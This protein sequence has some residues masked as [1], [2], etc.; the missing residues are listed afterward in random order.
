MRLLIP[1]TAKG[2]ETLLVPAIKLFIGLQTRKTVAAS[3]EGITLLGG[4]KGHVQNWVYPNW[5]E[6]WTWWCQNDAGL[7]GSE[8]TPKG[9]IA[10]QLIDIL[11]GLDGVKWIRNIKILDKLDEL[12]HGQREFSETDSVEV[13]NNR[14]KRLAYSKTATRNEWIKALLA[15]QQNGNEEAEEGI[16][17]Y[18]EL[19]FEFLLRLGVIRTG[20]KLKCLYCKRW[21][22]YL[23]EQLA[24]QLRCDHCLRMYEFPLSDPRQGVHWCYRPQGPF[25]IENYAEGQYSIALALSFL[26]HHIKGNCAWLPEIEIHFS[27]SSK[28]AD[29]VIWSSDARRKYEQ[30]ESPQLVIGECKSKGA[31]LSQ[32]DFERLKLWAESFPAATLAIAILSDK[33]GENEKRK[34][35]EFIKGPGKNSNLILLTGTELF[36]RYNAPECWKN[37]GEPIASAAQA[38]SEFGNR[39]Y[40]MKFLSEATQAIHL[41]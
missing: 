41:R 9:T 37:G 31:T 32:T 24:D 6:I 7:T 39:A 14:A 11:G 33:F 38:Y 20:A 3:S 26:K 36:S 13:S 10:N 35:R 25:S 17:E 22:W 40:P 15:A 1:P 19:H 34:I 29:F 8:I 2:L 12:A 18:V 30:C 28:E 27:N 16:D 4:G 21:S 5:H 23:I